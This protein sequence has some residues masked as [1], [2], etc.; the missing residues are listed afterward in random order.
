MTCLSP[1]IVEPR[2][3][4][5][6]EASNLSDTQVGDTLMSKLREKPLHFSGLSNNLGEQR[7]LR[8]TEKWSSSP[9]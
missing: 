3:L 5:T 1:K 6:S 8:R 4:N 9:T 2:C 7:S